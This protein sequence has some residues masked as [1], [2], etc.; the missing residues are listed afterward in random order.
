MA[1]GLILVK[2]DV[3]LINIITLELIIKLDVG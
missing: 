3:S 2:N 1:C